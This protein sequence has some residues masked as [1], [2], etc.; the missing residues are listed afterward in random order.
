MRDTKERFDR[1]FFETTKA[2][3]ITNSFTKLR[4]ISCRYSLPPGEYVLVPSTFHPRQEAE[5]LLRIFSE[6][7]HE[8]GLVITKLFNNLKITLGKKFE[9]NFQYL[10]DVDVMY[11]F[12]NVFMSNISHII[13]L[14]KKFQ[15]SE[16]KISIRYN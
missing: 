14:R 5:F 7:P 1:R 9:R 3:A 11:S 15:A 2:T 10:P 16:I 12:S 13:I 6:K 8:A 4:E